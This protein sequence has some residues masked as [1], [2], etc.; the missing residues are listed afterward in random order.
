MGKD[1]VIIRLPICKQF[2]LKFSFLSPVETILS[3][4]KSRES[5]FVWVSLV[6]YAVHHLSNQEFT[7]ECIT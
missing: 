5:Q 3:F 1:R 6:L 7:S 4:K 2:V